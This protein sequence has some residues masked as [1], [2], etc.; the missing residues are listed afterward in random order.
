LS[1]CSWADRDHVLAELDGYFGVDPV[2]IDI[3]S[4][5]RVFFR[6]PDA[7]QGSHSPDGRY[8]AFAADRA[9]KANILMSDQV[10]GVTRWIS[11]DPSD[12]LSGPLSDS[13]WNEDGSQFLAS[14]DSGT[15]IYD[16]LHL[17]KTTLHVS[18]DSHSYGWFSN[19]EVW[20]IDV[21]HDHLEAQYPGAGRTVFHGAHAVG[22]AGDTGVG[23]MIVARRQAGWRPC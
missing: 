16:V 8:V 2:A 6:S 17:T 13:V 10:T 19:H 18:K 15:F 9:G 12:S 5:K 21:W 11:D 1:A 4:G 3:H 23:P 7:W 20:A 14:N 22:V